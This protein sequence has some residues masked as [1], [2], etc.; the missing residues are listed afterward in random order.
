MLRMSEEKRRALN[1][2]RAQVKELERP[3]RE[4]AKI[5]RARSRR[6]RE[7]AID[8]TRTE[9]RKPRE[10]D[11]GYLAFLR[12]QCCVVGLITGWHCSGRIDPAHIRYSDVK[13]G[14][15]NPGGGMKP[16]DKWCLPVC[17]THHDAQHAYGDERKWWGAE[18][19]ADPLDLSAALYAA[20]Q[21][22]EDGAAVLRRFSPRGAR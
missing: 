22:G 8:R 14:K 19:G 7:A 15:V 17:R 2:L 21:A 3:E 13:A 9:Q 20:Y 1:S 18:V 6:K 5:A 11:N 12:R 16:D 4:A 10:R